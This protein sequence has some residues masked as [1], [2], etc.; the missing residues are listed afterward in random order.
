MLRR[1]LIL[2]ILLG[3]LF[4]FGTWYTRTHNK[5]YAG[6]VCDQSILQQGARVKDL[7]N[8]AE[9]KSTVDLIKTMPNYDKDPNCLYVIAQYQIASGDLSG[10]T[11]TL[12]KLKK[13]KTNSLSQILDSGK[14]SINTLQNQFDAMKNALDNAKGIPEPQT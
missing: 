6:K 7:G 10:A 11:D 14:A 4:A 9:F 2:V 8:L 1:L 5:S 13:E 12:N 3:G